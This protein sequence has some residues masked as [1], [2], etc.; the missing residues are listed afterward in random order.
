MKMMM[1]MFAYRNDQDPLEDDPD[2]C[3]FYSL[4]KSL[5]IEG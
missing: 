2:P 4:I 1:M 5:F 3:P